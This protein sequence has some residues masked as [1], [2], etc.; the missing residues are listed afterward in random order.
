M[1]RL[2]G[3]QRALALRPSE[4]LVKLEDELL[5]DMDLV[6][7]QEEELW[8]LKSRVNWMIQGDR[9]TNF[10]HVST[11]VRRK[12]NQ[13]MAIKNVVG[14]WINEEGKI[15]EFIRSGFEQIF[16]SSHSCVS[17]LDPA[18]SQWQL[19]LSELEKVNVSGGVSEE[20]IKAALWSLKPFKAPGP[21]GLH[22]GFFQKFWPIVGKSVI[23]EVQKIFDDRKVPEALNSTH[24]ALIPKIRGPETLGNY[25]PISLCNTVYKVVTKIIVARLRPYL[26]KI[27]SPMQTAF[28]PSRKGIDNIIIAQEI[29][30]SLGKKKGKTGYMALKIDLEKAYDKLEWNFI[31]DMLIRV[32]LPMD[33]IDV[34][35]SCVSTV[36]TSIL[37]NGEALDLIYPS[38][39][40]RQGDSLSPYLFIL[41]MDYL[42][43]LIEEK[44]SENLWQPVKASQSGP[45]FTHLFFADDLI[46]FAKA[47]GVNCATIR[48]VLDTFCNI[49]GQ[50]VSEAK[51][52]VYFSP[53]VDRDTR[54]ALCDILG[55]ASTPYLGKYLGFPLKQPGSS[56]HD[57]DFILDRVKQK[58]SGWKA[59]LLSLAGRR[60]LIQ[61][62]LA[63]IPSY[64]MQCSYLPGRVLNGLD[65]VNRNFL[66]GSTDLAKKIH[67]VGWE[68]VTKSKEEGGLGL[69]TV[70]G[71]NVA[72]LS[73]LN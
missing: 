45:A 71:R 70:K 73:K 39:G 49:S 72:L 44:C 27:I 54:E 1:S 52:R 7:K 43:Q 59:N 24:I 29:I 9:N 30:H 26:D 28:V 23:E 60:V 20:E 2:N 64:I 62:S 56:S 51:S 18:T 4:F 21:D 41:C 35:M 37:F 33:I 12:R 53:N 46:L 8:A 63:A 22:A 16:L 61:S 32:N 5:R 58:L 57:Y 15:K 67:W 65:R 34:I 6:L 3:I 55:F 42:G 25:R 14:D 31:R 38:R 50:T 48:E 19:R 68:K 17:R 11:L 47:D 66:W 69:H 13:I 40:I 36:F 10:Y